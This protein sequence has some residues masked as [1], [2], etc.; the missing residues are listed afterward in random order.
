MTHTLLHGF[1]KIYI[2]WEEEETGGLEFDAR[3]Y[4]METG[5]E[6]FEAVRGE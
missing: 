6:C 1:T 4:S 3:E 5:V 2:V